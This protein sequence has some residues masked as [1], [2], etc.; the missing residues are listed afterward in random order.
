[1]TGSTYAS[2][3]FFVDSMNVDASGTSTC[4]NAGL[5]LFT[6]RAHNHAMTVRTVV[7]I[8]L[9]TAPRRNPFSTVSRACQTAR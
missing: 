2:L 1:M 7:D 4:A 5:G 3:P 6:V 8:R 9:P